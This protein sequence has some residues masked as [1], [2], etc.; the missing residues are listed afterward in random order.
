MIQICN[1][2]GASLNSGEAGGGSGQ[3]ME[4]QV[5]P[6]SV[7]EQGGPEAAKKEAQGRGRVWSG[8]P[9]GTTGPQHA[10]PTQ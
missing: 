6:P 4:Q 7:G 1:Q 8:R 2:A 3:H 9:G 5:Q 10:G